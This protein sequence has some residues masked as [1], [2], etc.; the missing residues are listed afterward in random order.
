MAINVRKISAFNQL[1]N[2]TGDELLMVAYK[3]KTYKIPINLVLGNKIQSITQTKNNEDGADNPITITLSSG[4]SYEFHVY[5]GQKGSQGD[6]GDTGEKGDTGDSG[7]L[8]SQESQDEIIGRIINSFDDNLTL[9][10]SEL[11]QYMISAALGKELA[12]K[13]SSLKEIYC[14]EDEFQLIVDNKSIQEDTKYF[15]FEED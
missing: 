8:I 14:T 10:D 3:G 11:S 2:L 15:I 6:P 4:D 9:T 1:N 12:E 5:N 7:I 13:A